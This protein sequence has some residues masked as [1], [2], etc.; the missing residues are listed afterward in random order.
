MPSRPSGLR[1]L[2][3]LCELPEFHELRAL[4]VFHKA[5]SSCNIALVMI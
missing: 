5:N 2:R 4:P 3:E 1:E